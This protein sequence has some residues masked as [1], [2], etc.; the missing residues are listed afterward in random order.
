MKNLFSAFVIMASFFQ[1]SGQHQKPVSDDSKPV[2]HELW[3]TFVKKYVSPTGLVDYKAIKQ[4]ESELE[5]YLTILKNAR[6]SVKWTEN[7]RKAYWINAY[8]AFTI[9]L[10]V[11]NYPVKSI[12]EIGGK[13]KSPWDIDFIEIEGVKYSL[14]DIEHK[15]LRKEF[16]DPRIHAAINCASGS[17]PRLSDEA[18]TPESLD[19]QLDKAVSGFVNDSSRNNISSGTVQISPIFKWYNDDFTK[20]GSVTDFLNKYSDVK[21]NKNSKVKY[22]DYN[23]NLNEK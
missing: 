5:A 18:Y 12:K 1:C 22:S 9:K 21:I 4:N 10:V 15:I 6:P 3:N 8:N 20:N 23:W 14:N 17:C 13:F 19:K 11:D 7:E 16:D 2:S